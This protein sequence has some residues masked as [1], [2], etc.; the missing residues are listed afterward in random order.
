MQKAAFHLL[1]GGF[2]RFGVD[3]ARLFVFSDEHGSF[4]HLRIGKWALFDVCLSAAA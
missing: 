3:F 2:F 1:E 4:F